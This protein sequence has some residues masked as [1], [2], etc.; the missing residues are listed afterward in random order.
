MLLTSLTTT[1]DL[2]IQIN[3]GSTYLSG[4]DPERPALFAPCILHKSPQTDMSISLAPPTS[5]CLIPSQDIQ[6]HSKSC[7]AYS[8]YERLNLATLSSKQ[9]SSNLGFQVCLKRFKIE[10]PKWVS[11]KNRQRTSN[12]GRFFDQLLHFFRIVWTRGQDQGCPVLSFWCPFWFK[13]SFKLNNLI[14]LLVCFWKQFWG[15]IKPP[16]L[17]ISPPKNWSLI[18]FK[19]GFN[20]I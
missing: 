14:E 3:R 12:Q 11:S 18:W 7:Q 17:E 2:L 1:W 6:I 8:F 15:F 20:S 16:I 13:F 19:I 9:P 10:E 5:S 4:R